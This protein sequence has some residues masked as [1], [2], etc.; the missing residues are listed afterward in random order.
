VPYLPH[1]SFASP[2][3]DPKG[4]FEQVC[5]GLRTEDC[6]DDIKQAI[7]DKIVELAKAGERNPDIPQPLA[8]ARVCY[9]LGG[10]Y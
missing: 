6:A 2:L 5:I 10:R 3:L 7:A 8:P 4:A 1:C 9:G